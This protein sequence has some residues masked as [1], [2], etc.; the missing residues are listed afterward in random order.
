MMSERQCPVC[1]APVERQKAFCPECGSPIEREEKREIIPEIG[2][3]T[4][5]FNLGADEY[6]Q[7]LRDMNLSTKP[8]DEFQKSQSI[9]IA[10]ESAEEP[11]ENVVPAEVPKS[12]KKW[13]TILLFLVLLFLLLVVFLMILAFIFRDRFQ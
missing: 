8:A 2:G 13:L 1:A 12:S 6:Q 3:M 5:T 7:M 10:P 11:R 9:V 4:K